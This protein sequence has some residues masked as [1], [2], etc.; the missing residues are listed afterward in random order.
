[1][2]SRKWQRERQE[3]NLQHE[4]DIIVER[5]VRLRS[6]NGSLNRLSPELTKSQQ[7]RKDSNRSLMLPKIDEY[8]VNE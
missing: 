2:V 3:Q 4:N 7:R 6:Y 8:E 5:I 1:M